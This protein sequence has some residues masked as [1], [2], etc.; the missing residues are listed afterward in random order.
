[1]KVSIIIPV[2]EIN[3]YIRESIPHILN[4][5]NQDFEIIILPNENNIPFEAD[6]TK[7]VP[8]GNVWPAIK[9]NMWAELAQWEIL[10]FLDDDAY[11]R[12]DWLDNA[13]RFFEDENIVWVWWPWITPSDDP[14]WAKVSGAVFLT[15]L[16]W[17]NPERY[18]PV[19]KTKF[20][21][22][23]P[24]VNLLVRKS[25]FNSIGWFKWDYW[26]WE[27]TKLCLDLIQWWKKIVYSPEVVVWH[28]RRPWFKKHMNQVGN[29]GLHRGHFFRQWDTNSR[30]LSYI[31]PSLFI[32]FMSIWLII[33][34]S[35]GGIFGDLYIFWIS[36]YILAL[37]VSFL[38]IYIKIWKF[39]IAFFGI[40][41]IFFTHIVYW[42]K[43]LQWLFKS[44]LVSQL[45]YDR[46]LKIWS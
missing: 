46:K 12:K 20:V 43:F 13:I 41:Y 32:L 28:H 27:D 38:D 14:F 3:D 44:S 19:W 33:S 7:I 5:S 2:K 42:I 4:L 8:S 45:R 11:P 35:L 37:L 18:L 29:Y 26:P 15:K 40:I 34:L 25:D 39:R 21:D 17:W 24:S 6:K 10:A 16:W 9:R 22:D 1:M 23:W 31:V 36:V 30:N